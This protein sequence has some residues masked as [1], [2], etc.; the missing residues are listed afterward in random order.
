MTVF[1]H[2]GDEKAALG[3]VC[4]LVG[5]DPTRQSPG[6]AK[7]RLCLSQHTCAWLTHHHGSGGVSSSEM[8]V[9]IYQTAWC[10]IPEDSHLH[11]N[12]Y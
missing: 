9:S 8:S 4:V 10:I 3:D 1:H 6:R 5:E 12:K 11:L 7:L 2:Q